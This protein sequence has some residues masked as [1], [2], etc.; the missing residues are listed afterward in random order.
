MVPKRY[1]RAKWHPIGGS[2][3]RRAYREADAPWRGVVHTTETAGMP[4]YEDGFTAPHLTYDP[5][6]KA[7]Y[8]HSEF[9]RVAHALLHPGGTIET[10]HMHAIQLEIIAYSAGWIAD[11]SPHRQ[12]VTDLDDADLALIG[13]FW[14]WVSDE[15]G[16]ELA[17]Y[18]TPFRDARQRHQSNRMSESEWRS[19]NGLCGHN[20]VPHNTH[21]DP[22][23]FDDQTMLAYA[24]GS[25]VTPPPPPPE[26]DIMSKFPILRKSWPGET[27]WSF[28]EATLQAQ[29][30]V[31]GIRAGNTFDSN[32]TPDGLFGPGTERAVKTFQEREDLVVD[33][34]VGPATWDALYEK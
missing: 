25:P 29:L 31:Q 20:A 15:F 1:P 32:C 10:N 34:I 22:D 30:A 19:F 27:T 33:G 9:D 18:E 16:V 17:W 4:G 24:L 7:F 2:T 23:D 13:A 12:R 6:T 3:R 28:W 14:R 21:W 5:D 8:Q 26:E 11:Q